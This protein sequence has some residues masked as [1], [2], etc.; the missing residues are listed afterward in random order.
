MR[1][2]CPAPVFNRFLKAMAALCLIFGL[3]TV[4]ANAQP[5]VPEATVATVNPKKA[6]KFAILAVRPKAETDARWQPLID[7]LNT[8]NPDR[9]LELQ[10]LTYPE[11]EAAIRDKRI[12]F[13]L[14]QPGHY[15]TLTQ[16]EG[17]L[18]PLATLIETQ[19]GKPVS[20]LGGVILSRRDDKNIQNLA[21][22]AGKRIATSSTSSLGSYQAQAYELMLRGIDLS[23]D[24]RVIETGQPQDKA[25]VQLLAGQADAAFV[26]TGLIEAMA[27]ENK[28]DMGRLRVVNARE[29]DFPLAHST[30]LYPQWAL[31]A[32]PWAEQD[33]ARK[34]AADILTLPH[35]GDVARAA[36]IQGFAIPGDYRPVEDLLRHL[37][38]PP[39]EAGPDVRINDIVSQ[40]GL[41]VGIFGL[42][43]AGGLLFFVF[44]LFRSNRQLKTE[45]ARTALAMS[46]L[47]ATEARFRAIF[48]NVDALSI[49][50]YLA[51]GTVAYWNHASQSLYGYTAQEAIGRSLLELIIPPAMHEGV[52]G[53]VQWMFANKTGIPAGRLTLRHKDGHPVEVYSSHTVVDT[54]D[55]GTMM[56]CLDVDLREL[57]SAEQALT[58]SEAR[59]RMIL[60]TLGEGVFGTDLDDVCTFM[61]PAGLA[62][63][64]FGEQEV[65]GH[66][67]HSLFHHHHADGSLYPQ[68]ECP[69]RLTA[70][71][72]K[73]RR[74]DDVFWRK[75]G[76]MFP[77]RLTITPTLHDG[78]FSG[79]VVSFS[80]ISEIQRTERELEKHRHNLEAE[81][82]QRTEQL[83]IARQ[84]AEAASR[85]KSAFLANMSHEIRTPLNAVLGMVHLLRRDNPTPIQG[86]RLDKIDAASQHLLA[87]I[88]DIL[89]ISKIEAG[90]LQLD[91]TR[92]DISTIL[93]RVV[94]VLGER[95]RE[96]GLILNTESD[97]F[98]RMLIGDPTRITQCLINYAANAIK[99]TERGSVTVRVRR[100]AEA[101]SETLLRFEVE[102]TGIGIA[103]ESIPR[104]FGIF[105][106]ADASTTRKFGGTG[107][108]LAITRRLAALMGGEV[109]V[110][111]QPGRGSCFW[112]TARLKPS[113][114]DMDAITST[115][116]GL[117]L[118]AVRETLAGR[119]LL[120]VEDEPINREIALELIKEFG[121]TA[122][123][124]EN[125][126]EAL[127]LLETHSYDLVLMDMQ[128]P[129]MDGLE[130]TRR[131]R[132]KPRHTLLPIIAMTANAFAEDRE[133]CI[134]AGMNDFIVKPVEPDDLKM[135]LLRYLAT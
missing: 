34:F 97:D 30:R 50:G 39:F 58:E 120:I 56:F 112:F 47:S 102:D 65:L 68:S 23:T 87:V 89:D 13:V 38:L 15:I 124:A 106:Q 107:L 85:S 63:L 127:E 57:A 11:L 71:D 80:D 7:Y 29:D 90:K 1:D 123:T 96:K 48:E 116:A 115:F 78:K 60:E 28:L 104:L 62:L 134:E 111:S 73:T 95:A 101:N 33:F 76:E 105:E 108:G 32:M 83:E 100:V 61:N 117:P 51:N 20:A 46:E 88:N 81:V 10:A 5:P 31:A 17:L 14:T 69:L 12:D 37:R 35:G 52:S 130:A 131:I 110:S 66:S 82:R 135:L 4:D 3:S 133:R 16:R 21:D 24:A 74:V 118:V 22:L 43:I 18:S 132:A 8:A 44:T 109:G 45:R 54:A 91:E 122:D 128:M 70:H 125:G 9:P 59:Q 119:H 42:S 41:A 126:R 26:R 84:A 36:D 75:N 98:K 93:R 6:A 19:G 2:N 79:T 103:E 92:V 72:G 53:A 55:L 40:Y 114:E 67:T 129:E 94:S 27:R 64:G 25:I 121:T 86:D 113:D 99:F 49:Q 77:V